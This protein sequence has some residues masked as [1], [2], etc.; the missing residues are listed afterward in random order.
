MTLDQ[1]KNFRQ[2]NSVTPGHPEY[3]HTLGVETTTGPLGQGISTAVGMAIA[4]RI[5]NSRFGSDIV[6]HNTYVIA[7]DGDLMEGISH[8]AIG[9]AGHLGLSKLIVLYDSNNISIDGS[10][11]LSDSTDQ[12]KRFEASGWSTREV[13]GHDHNEIEEAIA[14]ELKT[15]CPSLIICKTTIGYGSPNKSD[16]AGIHGAAVGE[17]EASL[18]REFLNW[19]YPPFE[20]PDEVYT[21][22][23]KAITNG[24]DL[25]NQWNLKFE[26][27]QKNYPSEGAELKRMLKGQLP[28]NWDST[29]PSYS[30]DDK[31]LATRQ[32][33]QI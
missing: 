9:L 29:L 15:D 17:E 23:R 18:T 22:F 26:D 20:I 12:G 5:L 11:E 13:D 32:Q 6:D 3:G 33:S 28:E 24:E 2:L 8:E 31:G 1:I 16:T 14:D 30:P 19:E 21:Q 27:Y 7:S 25:E 4:E 10:L